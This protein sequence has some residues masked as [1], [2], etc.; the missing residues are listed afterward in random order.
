MNRPIRMSG[1]VQDITERKQVEET[2]R[3]AKEAAEAAA[4]AKSDFLANMSH[5]L[6]TPMNAVIGMTGL[7]LDT[8][9]TPEQQELSEIVRSSGDNLLTLINDILDYSKIEADR[10]ELE[11]QRFDL[12][13]C[14]EE[15]LD[16]LAPKSAEKGLELSYF[17]EAHTPGT[18]VGDITRLRQ[19][20][21]NLV[22][23]A[24]KFT[25]VGEVV[26]SVRSAH[27][28]ANHHELRFAVQDSGIGIPPERMDRLFLSFSQ[29]DASTTRR[30]GGTGLGLAI[31]KRL[32]E[33]LGGTMWVESTVDQGS[34]FFFTVVA[35]AVPDQSPIYLGGSQ[36]QLAGK[37]VL[38]VD[39]NA[40]NLRILTS[41][42]ESWGLRPQATV[43]GSEA[44]AWIRHGEPYHLAILDMQMPEMDGLTLATSIRQYRDACALP[45]VMLTSIG[46]RVAEVQSSQFA[47][48]M[49]K[50]IKTSALYDVLM[51]IFAEPESRASSLARPCQPTPSVAERQP[52][53]ILIAE[54]NVVNQKVAL[55][56]LERLGYRADVAA[57][58]VEV[59]ETLARQP[60]DVVLMDVQMPEMD[61]LEAT[62]RI[63]E[64]WS[65]AQRPRIIA[66][67]ANVMQED[68]DACLAAGMDDYLDKPMQKE[69]LQEVLERCCPRKT[70]GAETLF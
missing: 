27:L 4:E 24:V 31:S 23:N 57:N 25:E 15:A 30:Y 2:L 52:L 14:V 66:M 26:V 45:L 22:G 29:V 40:T 41:Q 64:Q 70:R 54:D 49:S 7:L 1:T 16:L 13:T 28:D 11:H 32:V 17:V 48:Y 35:E 46:R 47:A 21:V 19:I 65:T 69:A 8:G 50:P 5:E 53:R 68:R 59:L 61:G 20:L 56:M 33:L 43:S 60:Y 62:R 34:T 42:I 36:P 39:D 44:L 38:I 58:G 6:R 63:C 3:Q 37:R 51:N 12:R 10:V 9:L 18:L 67:T 55:R